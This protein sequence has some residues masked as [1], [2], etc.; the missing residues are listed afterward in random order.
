MAVLNLAKLF[1]L[2]STAILLAVVLSG[3]RSNSNDASETIAAAGRAASR[4]FTQAKDMMWGSNV[5]AGD[6][7]DWDDVAVSVVD[8]DPPSPAST[9]STVITDEPEP[10]VTVAKNSKPASN[11]TGWWQKGWRAKLAVCTNWCDI[12][13][14]VEG[15]SGRTARALAAAIT[16]N[17]TN[18][19]GTTAITNSSSNS[20]STEVAAAARHKKHQ[21]IC[22]TED[23]Y[24]QLEEFIEKEFAPGYVD[25]IKKSVKDEEEEE[26]DF[27]G[28]SCPVCPFPLAAAPR[29]G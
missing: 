29:I 14:A 13:L 23:E 28:A 21:P 12:H 10:T 26:T 11:G 22:E 17:A 1:L 15:P 7:D 4:A 19:N 2:S 24:K 16:T 3:C 27:D 9:S 5:D 20:T 25:E 6:D 8:P 18:L